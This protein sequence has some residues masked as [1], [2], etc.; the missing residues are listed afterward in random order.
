MRWCIGNEH[1]HLARMRPPIHHERSS[2]TSRDSLRPITSA[3]RVQ[4]SQVCVDLGDIGRKAEDLG[5]ECVVLR[6]VVPKGDEADT[7]VFWL[8]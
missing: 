2:E 7:Q 3:R 6:W 5:H 1:D 8:S 4:A